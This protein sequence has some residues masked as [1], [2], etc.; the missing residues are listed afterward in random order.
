MVKSR[1]TVP[2]GR[3]EFWFAS[4]PAI[5]WYLAAA[6]LL[7]HL[8]TASRYG[9]FGDELYYMACGQHLA[10]GYVDQ[11][12][13]IAL[14]AWLIRHLLGTSVFA[15][16]VIPA[17]AGCLL[18][19]LTG[20]LTRELG[21]G[22]FA[23]G[24]A[25]LCV[26][27]AGAYLI[28]YHLLTMNAFEPLLWMACASLVIRI[29]KTGD[30]RLWLWFGVVAG[31]GLENKYS[32]LLFGAAIVVGLLLARQWRVFVD[33]WIWLAGLVTFLLFLPNL[34]WNIQHHWPFLELMHNIRA[35]GRDLPFTPLGYLRAQII[36]MAPATFPV[37]FLGVLYLL[38]WREAKPLR[39]L[40]WA[41]LVVLA[42]L[43]LLHG[44][45]YYAVPVYP[46]AFAAGAIAIERLSATRR[47]A[48]LRYAV[49]GLIVLESVVLLPLV[50]P[51]LSPAGF[52]KYQARLPF[53]IQPDEKSMAA[54]PMP[55][56]YSFCFGW[57]GLVGGVAKAYFSLPA[58]ERRDTAIY[59]NDFA[60]AGAIDLIG[61]E[62]GLPKAISSHQSYWLWGPHGFTGQTMIVV[63]WSMERARRWFKKVS[64]AVKLQN[65]YVRPSENRPVLLCRGLK[66]FRALADAWPD[67]KN[68]D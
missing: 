24:L 58:E 38:V 35:S 10:W 3:R 12:P 63:G 27:C 34:I 17:L 1:A 39:A 57:H 28:L 43:V 40:G 51:V 16:R 2:Q 52:L 44:K 11:P 56:Y 31:I 59:A 37:W 64:V 14:V 4:G 5:V 15:V 36:L 33:R 6:V 48:W 19:W 61:P 42:A 7:L 53:K 22:R 67:L 45:D 55:H 60:A 46:M 9:Y 23:Q 18:V 49:V 30:N 66:G 13:L 20:L 68:W 62:Y 65:P 8:L 29:I 32:M 21:G 50:A 26:A 41:F 47:S 54:E 25:A